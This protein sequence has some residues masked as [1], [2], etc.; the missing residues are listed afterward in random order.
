MS[1]QIDPVLRLRC[2]TSGIDYKTDT[3][4]DLCEDIYFRNRRLQKFDNKLFRYKSKKATYSV[5]CQKPRQPIVMKTNPANNPKISKDS[6]TFAIKYGSDPEHQN[7]YICPK[8][9]C[10]YCEIPL[11]YKQVKNIRETKTRTGL[12][13]RGTCPYGDHEVFI[14]AY[15]KYKDKDKGLY[16]GFTKGK[17]PDGYCLPCCTIKDMRNPKFSDHNMFKKCLGEKDSSTDDDKKDNFYI[18]DYNKV[19]LEPDRLGSMTINLQHLFKNTYD[20]GHM[21]IGK[22]Y[23]LRSGVTINKKQSFLESMLKIMNDKINTNST[24]VQFK[25]FL[26]QKISTNKDLFSSLN[27][28]NLSLVFSNNKDITPLENFKR[29]ILSNKQ[30]I[31]HKYMWDLLSRPGILFPKGL[32]IFIFTSNVIICPK[33]YNISNIYDL[34]RDSIFIYNYNKFYEPIYLVKYL[35]R[36][37]IKLINTFDMEYNEPGLFYNLILKY[38]KQYYDIDWD[39]VLKDNIKLLNIKYNIF[40]TNESTF[41]DV[42]NDINNLD[43][44]YQIECQVVDSYNKVIGVLLKNK[45]FYPIKPTNINLDYK[46]CNVDYPLLDLKTTI[47]LYFKFKNKTKLP[48]KIVGKV[49][50]KNTKLINILV[51]ETGRYIFIKPIKNI[52]S[53]LPL[54]NIQY[55]SEADE[56]IKSNEIIEDHRSILSKKYYYNNE[57][58]IRYKFEISK[59][60]QS[61]LD[62]RSNI[63][64][65]IYSDD[66]ISIKIDKMKKIIKDLTKTL[67]T[68]KR[69]PKIEIKDYEISNIRIPCYLYSKKYKSAE[70][71]KVCL[72]DYHCSYLDK[73]CKYY[74]P[75]ENLINNRDNYDIYVNTISNNLLR[76]QVERN[77][78]INYEFREIIEPTKYTPKE[79]EIF[80]FGPNF[81]EQ[82]QELYIKDTDIF[83]SKTIPLDETNPILDYSSVDKM[84]YSDAIID[85]EDDLYLEELNVYWTKLLKGNFKIFKTN[86]INGSMFYSISRAYNTKM[87]DNI[88]PQKIKMMLTDYLQAVKVKDLCNVLKVYQKNYPD[89]NI[90]VYNRDP[91]VFLLEFYQHIS[92]YDY[93]GITTFN[94]LKEY[95]L[96]SN[97]NGCI[98]DLYF[99]S[100]I[101]NII[102]ANIHYRKIPSNPDAFSC[103]GPEL[104]KSNDIILLYTETLKDSDRFTYDVVQLNGN[105]IFKKDKFP[106]QFIKLLNKTCKC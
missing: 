67:A 11:N 89:D 84:F 47:K 36:N 34:N 93:K 55:F 62:I 43:K 38:C 94:N 4:I 104:I 58:Y 106:N 99:L 26:V 73:K 1:H 66:K 10:P 102:I 92:P 76:N 19:P 23:F 96:T 29:F 87:E 41:E 45:L 71:K 18:L 35:K 97:Y 46:V 21:D 72:S 32:N 9:W 7:Y 13:Y 85:K 22:N 25:N 61:N 15:E 82:F 78:I 60:L 100:I 5:M 59:Y 98:L 77:E 70:L 24:M 68:N 91:Q 44:D 16:P 50:D 49:M 52:D 81:V 17:H 56:Y 40:S 30:V 69:I 39:R 83:I 74:F 51:L 3:C 57:S 37:D 64:N 54:L 2:S 75:K 28:G 88:T 53:L 63:K 79:G 95:I 27:N 14:E 101:L 20:T 8:V 33:G 12:C 80:I 86:I 48:Y 31:N 105:Y 103:F 6:Y 90:S 65:I 42:T